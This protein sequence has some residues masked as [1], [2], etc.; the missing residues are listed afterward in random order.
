MGLRPIVCLCAD[1]RGLPPGEVLVTGPGSDCR[2]GLVA[3]V[4]WAPSPP[5]RSPLP[6]PE[7]GGECSG[8]P[9]VGCPEVVPTA[10]FGH[11]RDPLGNAQADQP[12]TARP[13]PRSSSQAL[14]PTERLCD[15][16]FE[17]PQES[18]TPGHPCP[19]RGPPRFRRAPSAQSTPRS[20]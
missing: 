13:S 15:S 10:V 1:G 8:R 3:L 17:S 20:T 5:S 6:T 14:C 12:C 19:Q 9:A 7:E 16:V 2:L 18:D 4:P 11:Q